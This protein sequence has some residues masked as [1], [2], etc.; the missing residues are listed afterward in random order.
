[1][2]RMK[3][4]L[5]RPSAAKSLAL[6]TNRYLLEL[7][8][9]RALAEAVVET[10]HHPLLVL[11]KQLR[12]VTANR[13]YYH[14]FDADP[15][16]VL[17]QPFYALSGGRWNIAELRSLL[18]DVLSWH[19]EVESYEVED[20]GPE[21]ERRTT[22]LNAREVFYEWNDCALILVTI[23]DITERRAS[24]R[25]TAELL[26]QKDV[27]LKEMQHRMANSL[28]IIAS[29]LL[30]KARNVRSDEMRLH[31]QDAHHRIMTVAAIQ[32]QLD[33]SR[34]GGQ[35]ELVPYLT[36][37]CETLAVSMVGDDRPI[38][39][40]VQADGATASTTEAVSIGLIVTE[41]VINALKHAFADDTTA[42]LIVVSYDVAGA[43]WTL[44]ISDNGSGKANGDAEKPTPGLG[45]SI[46]EALARQ[47]DGR[48]VTSKGADGVGTSV[49]IT[50]GPFATSLHCAA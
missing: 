13:A 35:I 30:L 43:G 47:L 22:L 37:L 9:G 34:H 27:L 41:L 15:A 12:V 23:E 39:I 40:R 20:H 26:E 48:V 2:Q 6:P 31:L 33:A 24:E 14:T 29:I 49:S 25:D 45:T 7:D 38:A 19:T 1:M 3:N 8:E 28:Q 42:G 4:W 11:D 44:T 17:D 16:E 50:H 18:T 46:V 36:R 5:E 32:Q 21:L 10:I